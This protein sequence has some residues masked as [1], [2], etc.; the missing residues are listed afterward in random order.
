MMQK[1]PPKPGEYSRGNS[2]EEPQSSGAN[3]YKQAKNLF[4]KKFSLKL[5]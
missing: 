3:I 5:G 4:T 1:S 2:P